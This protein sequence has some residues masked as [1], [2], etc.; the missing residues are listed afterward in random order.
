MINENDINIAKLN[1]AIVAIESSNGMFYLPPHKNKPVDEKYV[2]EV[3]TNFMWKFGKVIDW[4]FITYQNS[5]E[6][7]PYIFG[8]M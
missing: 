7:T 2:G 3:F 8:V 4:K 5:F 1:G 6:E